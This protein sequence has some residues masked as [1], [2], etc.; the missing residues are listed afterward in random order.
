MPENV[1]LFTDARMLEHDAGAGHVERPARLETLLGLIDALPE[2]VSSA[3]T[4]EPVARE[5][6]HAVHDPRYVER[7]ASFAGRSARLDPDTSMS[8]SSWLAAQIAAGCAVRAVESVLAGEARR[9]FALVRPPGHHA[10]R[11]RA[12]GFC[13]LNNV[14]IAAS[15]A[16]S[17][18]ACARVLIVDWDVHHGNGTQHIF[19][20]RDD[21]LFFS[22]HQHPFYPGTGLLHETGHGR[23]AGFTVN[24]PIPAGCGD[25]EY[26]RLLTDLLGPT[27][28]R[29]RPD[30]ILVSAG[31]D[32]HEN[33]PLGGMRVTA[34]GFGALA[35]LVATL[36]DELCDG[37]L[38]LCLE[39]GYDLG[40]LGACVTRVLEV[41]A[42]TAPPSPVTSAEGAADGDLDEIIAFHAR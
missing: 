8:P 11:D 31:F 25:R 36:A 39:G 30:L 10:E 22:V 9:A 4:A 16:L 20:A 3:T 6:V 17:D 15:R 23:G 42:G 40:G 38:A 14:A 5:L 24:A 34:D 33:D 18:P 32:A 19:E 13:L 28:R 37:R 27:A 12:M 26:A 21:V 2:G 41:L 7:L 29:F 1:A 35:G